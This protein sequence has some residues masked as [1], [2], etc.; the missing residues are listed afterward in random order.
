MTTMYT[1][2]FIQPLVLSK[3]LTIK[4]VI[5]KGQLKGGLYVFKNLKLNSSHLQYLVVPCKPNIAATNTNFLQTFH[6]SNHKNI[7]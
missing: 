5:F 3:D 1:L 2:N 6:N 7:L 4:I